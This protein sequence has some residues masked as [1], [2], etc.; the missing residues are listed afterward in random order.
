[1]LIS[2]GLFSRY[3]KVGLNYRDLLFLSNLFLCG[4]RR[5]NGYTEV[6]PNSRVDAL[7]V[8]PVYQSSVECQE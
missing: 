1:M 4:M 3:R 2:K 6:I 5:V 8:L 7:R